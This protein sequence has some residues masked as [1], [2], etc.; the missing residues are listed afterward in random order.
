VKYKK[1]GGIMNDLQRF[2]KDNFYD[3]KGRIKGE[4]LRAKAPQLPC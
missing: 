3:S 2:F 1:K 4:L